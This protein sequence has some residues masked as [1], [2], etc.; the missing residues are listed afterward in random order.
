M[1]FIYRGTSRGA[2]SVVVPISAVTGVALSVASGVVLL[3]DRPGLSAWLGILLVIPALWWVA[4][5]SARRISSAV[6]NG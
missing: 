1:L 2:V 3:G 4:C 6:V 5:G